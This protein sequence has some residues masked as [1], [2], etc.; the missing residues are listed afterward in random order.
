MQNRPLQS[1]P[2]LFGSSASY[3]G[4]WRRI[5]R[6]FRALPP[7]ACGK[8]HPAHPPFPER[9]AKP[10]GPVPLC[11]SQRSDAGAAPVLHSDAGPFDR[12][13]APL[14]TWAALKCPAQW[15]RPKSFAKR[16]GRRTIPAPCLCDCLN[17]GYWWR[18][19][20]KAGPRDERTTT[21]ALPGPTW[22]LRSGET[23]PAQCSLAAALRFL[24]RSCLPV[25]DRCRS[26]D[27]PEPIRR[28]GASNFPP[29][30]ERCIRKGT[31]SKWFCPAHLHRGQ[32]PDRICRCRWDE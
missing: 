26:A 20:P 13:T 19:G 16:C 25:W 17:I 5:P 8:F 29:V 28:S 32:S 3:A 7:C 18:T 1:A 15:L 12:N 2:A 22:A 27:F 11:I 4:H 10:P 14:H 24:L 9:G 6:T 30:S 31:A 21:A 23:H